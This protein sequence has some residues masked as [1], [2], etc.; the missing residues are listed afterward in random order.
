MA[1]IAFVAALAIGSLMTPFLIHAEVYQW[2]D[3]RGIIH[4]T[5]D[6]SHIPSSY[7]EQLKV[8]IRRDI[9]EEETRSEP[10]KT[11]SRSKEQQAKA[12]LYR[13]EEA[14]WREK[15]SPWQKQLDEASENYELTNKEFLRE[16]N[17]LIV[18]KFG[19]HQQ[20]KSTIL[21]MERLKEQK[22]QYEA[23]IIEAKGM[24]EKISR[25]A[26]ESRTNLGWL[27]A[28]VT[29]R[30]PTSSDKVEKDIYGR[31]EAWW[32]QKVHT[33]R[34]KLKDAVQ[35]YERSYEEYSKNAEKLGPVRF[36]GM[37]LTQYQMTSLT[38][39]TLNDQMTQYQARIAEAREMLE[40]L[41][42]EAK[43]TKADPAWL[44]EVD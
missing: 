17:N 19:S 37:S 7:R 24:L 18:R 29:S 40:K 42:M 44:E 34:E 16:S 8:E 12:D 27:I 5:D 21:R 36:G 32:R 23:Q 35:N 30:Q 9:Q 41:C 3:D 39:T 43:E 11:I 31:D 25:Q 26:E 13:Q 10:Q 22:S 2:I 28:A 14:W 1:T 15:A 4:F 38:L 6:Y 33:V 20:Y